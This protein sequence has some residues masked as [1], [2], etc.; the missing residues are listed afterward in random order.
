ML[1]GVG[2]ENKLTGDAGGTAGQKGTVDMTPSVDNVAKNGSRVNPPSPSGDQAMWKRIVELEPVIA[3]CARRMGWIYQADASEIANQMRLALAEK[4]RR[5][6]RLLH[7]PES[8]IF[9]ALCNVIHSSFRH[10]FGANLQYQLSYLHESISD[11][12]QADMLDNLDRMARIE[13]VRDALENSGDEMRQMVQA[14]MTNFDDVV[15]QRKPWRGVTRL[16]LNVNE[17]ARK[18]RMPKSRI[19]EMVHDLQDALAPVLAV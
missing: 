13:A 11:D 4:A 16:P 9:H 14:I 17:L 19:Y 6:P 15:R 1:L 2:S 5:T 12:Q 18:M 7:K 10:Q 3:K 8:Y